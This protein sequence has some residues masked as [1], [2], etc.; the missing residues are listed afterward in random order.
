[1]HW[2]ETNGNII[3]LKSLLALS[4]F[5]FVVWKEAS[6][7]E[8]RADPENSWVSQYDSHATLET[9]LTLGTNTNRLA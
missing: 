5:E 7:F 1:M 2:S 8:S 6:I 3:V 9:D 4:K